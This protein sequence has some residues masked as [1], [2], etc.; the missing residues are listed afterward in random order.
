MITLLIPIL[1]SGVSI[2]YSFA[3]NQITN[4]GTNS[5]FEFDIMAQ[6]DDIGTKHGDLFIVVKY[7]TTAFGELVYANGKLDITLGTLLTSAWPIYEIYENDNATNRFAVTVEYALSQPQFA[8]DLPTM[9]TQLLHVKLQIANHSAQSGLEFHPGPM[10]NAQY[11]SDHS[12]IYSPVYFGNIL[13]ETL[14]VELSSFTAT[15]TA[16]Q[17]VQVAWVA[18]S[19]TSHLGYNILRGEVNLATEAIRINPILIGTQDG[20]ASGTQV[21]YAYTDTEVHSNATYYYWLES[22]DLGGTST[23]HGPISILVASQPGDPAIPPLPPTLT[24]LLPVYPNPFNPSTNI[25]YSLKEPAT[26]RIE[27]YNLKGQL[28]RSYENVY[29]SPGF[30]QISWDGKDS[31]GGSVSSGVYLY[32]MTAGRYSSHRKMVLAK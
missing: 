24:Q 31:K 21:S 1:A 22:L 5:Y 27:I 17:Y 6:A 14:P 9:A 12:T 7:N 8:N 4:D 26:V 29:D 13:D 10:L 30:Y 2:T 32:R 23:L 16:E 18:Q 15:L 11:Q 3:N 25:R 28:M 20:T 19:E